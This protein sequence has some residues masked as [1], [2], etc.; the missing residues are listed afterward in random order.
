MSLSLYGVCDLC[1]I[2][3]FTKQLI[4]IENIIIFAKYILLWK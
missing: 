1:N 4:V 3:E 2:I